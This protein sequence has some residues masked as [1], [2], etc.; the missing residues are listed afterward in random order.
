MDQLQLADSFDSARPRLRSLAYRMLGSL[1]EAEDAVQDAWLRL[2]RADQAAIQD[3]DAWLTTVVAR[4]ALNALRQRRTHPAESLNAFATEPIITADAGSDPEQE[5]LLAEAVGVA[6]QVVIDALE[7]AQRLAFVLHDMF[8]VPFE[9]IAVLLDR[10]PQ[11]TRQLAS[12]ARR[13]V[14]GEAPSPDPDLGRQRAVVDAYFAAAREGDLD[15][16]VAV[17]DPAVVARAHTRTG[18]LGLHGAAQVAEAAMLGTRSARLIRS[19]L[20]NGAAG[21]VAFDEAGVPFAILAFTVVNDR[22]L[23]IDIFNDRE[24]VP[25]LVRDF[26]R[27]TQD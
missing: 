23:I 8:A 22:A 7:P 11:A 15:A 1:A 17:L 26:G 25:P 14:Q 18:V 4:L 6:L 16:L 24:L 20:V 19:A 10:S 12:R 21:S 13:R 5:V 27:L 9:E 2:Q 3:L